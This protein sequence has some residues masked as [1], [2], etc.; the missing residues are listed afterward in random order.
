MCFLRVDIYVSELVDG[1][2]K[3]D[4]IESKKPRGPNLS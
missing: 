4:K 2:V 3:G 1:D